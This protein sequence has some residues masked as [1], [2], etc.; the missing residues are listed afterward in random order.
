MYKYTKNQGII[1][2][3]S[4]FLAL[5]TKLDT[6][7]R[8]GFRAAYFSTDKNAE[9]ET[10]LPQTTEHQMFYIILLLLKKVN[11]PLI[12]AIKFKILSV[13]NF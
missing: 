2:L 10:K 7:K 5:R 3:L 9:A 12:P 4:G 8:L 1:S 11:W 6:M 13:I